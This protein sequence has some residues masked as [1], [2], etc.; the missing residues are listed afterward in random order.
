MNTA[1][2][3]GLGFALLALLPTSSSASNSALLMDVEGMVCWTCRDKI[4]AA[5][6][7][8]PFVTKVHTVAD[9]N[10]VCVETQGSYNQAELTQVITDLEYRVENVRV[11]E[12]C[13]TADLKPKHPWSG[14]TAGRDVVT[15]SNGEEVKIEEHL[16]PGKFTVIDFG[17]PWCS[18]C[19]DAAET[20]ADRLDKHSDLAVRVVNLES[21]DINESYALPAAQQH[22]QYAPGIPWFLVFDP[23]G[24]RIYKGL[25]LNKALKLIAKKRARL[26]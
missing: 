6:G 12:H 11:K 14:K 10:A 19:Y 4:E 2:W 23:K 21:Q 16:V 20:L 26:Q 5:L 13:P 24:N 9:G 22:L 8:L 18:P 1:R 3:A 17:A 15:I 7:P 25:D